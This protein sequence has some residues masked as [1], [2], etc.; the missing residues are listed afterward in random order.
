MNAANQPSSRGSARRGRWLWVLLALAIAP[1]LMGAMVVTNSLR[2]PAPATALREAWLEAS[3]PEWS[4]VIQAKFGPWIAAGLRTGARCLP[5]ETEVL[6]AVSAI[7]SASVA[8]YRKNGDAKSAN[9]PE[10]LAAGDVAMSR[11]GWTRVVGVST[12]SETVAVY[13]RPGRSENSPLRLCVAVREGENLVVAYVA[14]RPEPLLR[15]AEAQF[16][17]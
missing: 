5:L 4:P 11:Y 10:L 13:A 2:Q 6:D 3:G 12:A 16:S 1:F 15:L 9:G 17:Q 8:V 7:R 14:A